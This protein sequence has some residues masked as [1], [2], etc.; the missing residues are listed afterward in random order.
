MAGLVVFD[1]DAG[2]LAERLLH[3]AADDEQLNGVRLMTDDA[4]LARIA[5]IDRLLD[6]AECWGAYVSVLIE[7]RRGH[8]L[9]ITMEP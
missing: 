6:A 7:E 3:H 2:V 5:E 8:V 1:H 9:A 4:R